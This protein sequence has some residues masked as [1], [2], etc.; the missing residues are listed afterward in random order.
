MALSALGLSVALLG[1][2]AVPASA[3]P[4]NQ[5]YR[6]WGSN[7]QGEL[8]DGL[9]NGSCNTSGLQD[10]PTAEV[11]TPDNAVWSKVSTGGNHTVGLKTN[12][13]VWVWGSNTAGQLGINTVCNVP[14]TGANCLSD[15]PVQVHGVGNTGFLTGVTDVAAGLNHSFAVVGSGANSTVVGWGANDF[16]QMGNNTTT[17]NLYPKLVMNSAGTGNLLGVVALGSGA[18]HGLGVVGTGTTAKVWAWGWNDFGELGDG[19]TVNRLLPVQVKG[20]N[21]VGTLTDISRIAGGYEH[22]LALRTDGLTLYSWG[23]NGSGQLGVG[24]LPPSSSYPVVVS[25]NTSIAAISVG[26]GASHNLELR[27]GGTVFAWGDG[28][29]GELGQG[30]GTTNLA[31]Q[32]TPVQVKNAAGSGFLAGAAEVSGGGHHSLVRIGS[33]STATVL[34]FGDNTRGQLG[35]PTY[36]GCRSPDYPAVPCSG[37]PITVQASAGGNLLGASQIAA[38]Y[39]FSLALV[40]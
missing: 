14:S 24:T 10:S 40:P 37:L 22:A 15:V 25:R 7:N 6:G 4:S 2:G 27:T 8:G 20:V 9:C 39:E 19:T 18:N 35:N 36:T 38:G 30:N 31:N 28:N 21:G 13:E 29:S 33:G 26:P 5:R 23:N 1:V 16:G 11:P 17:K 12:G 34:A 32:L 3:L